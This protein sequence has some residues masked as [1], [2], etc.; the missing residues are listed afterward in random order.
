MDKKVKLIAVTYDDGTT[1]EIEKGL[2]VT[3][4]ED[5]DDKEYAIVAVDAVD[6][7]GRD[8]YL[9]LKGIAKFVEMILLNNNKEDRE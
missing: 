6:C 4:E 7:S 9:L 1:R 5:K 2:C 8:L 3:V